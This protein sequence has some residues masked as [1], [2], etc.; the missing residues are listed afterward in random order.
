M[1]DFTKLTKKDKLELGIVIDKPKPNPPYPQPPISASSNPTKEATFSDTLIN[2][3][4]TL[5]EINATKEDVSLVSDAERTYA[6]DVKDDSPPLRVEGYQKLD[7]LSPD[8]L[9]SVY[10][11]DIREQATILYPWQRDIGVRL[12]MANPNK[13]KPYKHVLCAANGSG[14]DAFVITPF[15]VW[16][17]LSKIKSRCIIT[18]SSGVQLTSQTETY[19]ADLC[20]KVNEFHKSEIFK[21]RQRFIKCRLTGSEI[22]LFATDEEGKA[23]GYHPLEP[24]AEMAIIINE[25]KSVDPMIYRAL[26]RCTGYNYWLEV[27]TPADQTGDFY[28]HFTTW[29]NAT[30]ISWRDCPGHLSEAERLEDLIEYGEHSM[31]YRSKWEALFTSANVDVIIPRDV[32]DR[33]IELSK[34]GNTVAGYDNMG[35][36]VGIDLSAGGDETSCVAI[37]GNRIIKRLNFR[38]TDTTITATRI[39]MWLREEMRLSKDFTHA[40]GDDGGVGK[41]II[42]QLNSNFGWSIARVNNQSPSSDKKRYINRGAENWYRIKRIFE[43]NLWFFSPEDEL[44]AKLLNQLSTR[45]YKQ[46]STQGRIALESKKEAK[47]NGRPSPDRADALVLSLTGITISDYL[48]GKETYIEAP[49]R[50]PLIANEAVNEWFENEHTYKEYEGKQLRVVGGRKGMSVHNLVNRSNRRTTTM[51]YGN[52]S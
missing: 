10:S 29:P 44:D 25:A 9:L 21:I 27:S 4:A 31:L 19:I 45:Y 33:G 48:N 17:A 47:A 24:N 42:D 32:I 34:K 39:D 46:Q 1:K 18:S 20:R 16:F 15:A 22:R 13:L 14:K 26:R 12:A 28:T 2:N 7:F 36:R 49:A 40:Y 52:R 30:R 11:K 38:E 3:D 51:S 43:E 6:G 23:E 50:R 35:V 41:S 37:R 5:N 8:E